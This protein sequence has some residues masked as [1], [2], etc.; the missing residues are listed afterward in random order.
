[1][2][3]SLE[4]KVSVVVPIKDEV[5][6]IGPLAGEISAALDAAN[7]TWECIWVDDLSTDGTREKLKELNAKDPRH[8]YVFHERNF[9][10]SA[11]LATGF[12]HVRYAITATLDGDGQNDPASLPP[13]VDKLI[14]EDADMVN[15]WRQKRQDGIVRKISSKIGN[16]FRNSLTGE[17]IRDVGCALRVFRSECA[18]HIPVFKGMH[19]FFPTLVRMAGYGKILE[20]PVNHRHRIRGK[21]KYGINNRLWVGIADTVA[22][23]WMRRRNVYP[24]SN[25]TSK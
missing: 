11:G 25:E 4:R 24:K 6:N 9:G 10:Q 22:I 21:T 19:R 3:A 20:M 5:E 2:P 15:G 13:L 7:I 12:R 8:R 23:C 16:G 14:A 17:R 1:M 18:S